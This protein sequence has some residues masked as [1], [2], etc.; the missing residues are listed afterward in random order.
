MISKVGICAL[1]FYILGRRDI[2]EQVLVIFRLYVS[3]DGDV[4]DRIA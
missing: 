2:V 3:H 4:V 1:R